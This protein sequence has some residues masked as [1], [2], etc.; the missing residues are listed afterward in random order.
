MKERTLIRAVAFLLCLFLGGALLLLVLRY[1]LPVLFPF[2]LSYFL[3]VLIRPMA[4]KLSTLTHLPT[5]PCAAI[6]FLLLLAVLLVGI[7]TALALL[8][9]ELSGL[10]DELLAGEGLLSQLLDALSAFS[11]RLAE[12]FPLLLRFTGG[13]PLREQLTLWL[14]KLLNRL[15]TAAGEQLPGLVGGLLSGLPLMLLSLAAVIFS[16]VYFCMGT[17]E[18][19]RALCALL[20]PAANA[21]LHTISQRLKGIAWGYLRSYFQLWLLTFAELW[22]GLS[23]LSV[24]YAFLAALLISLVDLLPVLGVG[25]VLLPWSAL[26]FFAWNNHFLGIGMPVLYLVILLV[27]QLVEPRLV[28][29]TLGLHPL[30]TL[31][32]GYAG[33]RLFGIT[34]LFLVPPLAVLGKE[35]LRQWKH[36]Q[37]ETATSDGDKGST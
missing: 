3:S 10:L 21:R 14:S 26:A 36:Q 31:F 19:Q 7:G 30:L 25:T 33:F 24:K 28:G 11:D 2:L 1:A 12:R 9:G 16:G 4:K 27:R 29:R 8:V 15:L 18:L 5:A 37:T 35:L 13:L 6:L 32:F 17:E 34:G 22:L 23:I 20:P